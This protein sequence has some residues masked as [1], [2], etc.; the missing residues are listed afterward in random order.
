[1]RDIIGDIGGD[2]TQEF[3]FAVRVPFHVTAL[4][5]CM[6]CFRWVQPTFLGQRSVRVKPALWVF[7][8]EHLGTFGNWVGLKDE[9]AN[10]IA[11]FV[12]GGVIISIAQPFEEDA[13][14]TAI[15][16]VVVRSI[17]FQFGKLVY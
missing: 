8:A 1:M 11:Y 10:R 2:V 17:A 7:N 12:E 16:R 14:P 13:K 4:Q 6:S 9:V 15:E 3:E 5:K